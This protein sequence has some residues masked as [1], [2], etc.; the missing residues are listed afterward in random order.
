MKPIFFYGLFM[1]FIL[2][3]EKGFHP[4]EPKLAHVDGFGLRIGERATL[5]PAK[6]ERAYGIVMSLSEDEANALYGEVSVVDY[7]SE[8]LTAITSEG[9]AIEVLSYNLPLEMLSG[10]NKRYAKSLAEVAQRIGLP[11][12]YVGEIRDWSK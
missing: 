12:T 6:N 5:V 11:P 1:D 4:S 9:M 7:V 10:K 3:K 2:L 8:E